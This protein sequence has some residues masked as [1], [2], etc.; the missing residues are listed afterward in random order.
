MF[1]L[2]KQDKN[3]RARLGRLTTAHGQ[4]QTPCFMPVGT[5]ATVKGVFQ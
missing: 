2:L 3:T 1:E 5:H 4:I